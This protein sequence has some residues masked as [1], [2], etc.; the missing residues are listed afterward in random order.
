MLRVTQKFKDRAWARMRAWPPGFPAHGPGLFSIS[1]HCGVREPRDEQSW[2]QPCHLRGP[3]AKRTKDSPAMS[4]N[5][6]STM[7]LPAVKPCCC[8]S[9]AETRPLCG[10][11]PPG[12]QP[13]PVPWE[14]SRQVCQGSRTVQ[15]EETEIPSLAEERKL[16]TKCFFL[17]AG[18][19]QPPWNFLMGVGV[20]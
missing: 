13:L 20:G 16:K 4:G 17:K 6:R 15:S 9:E 5:S 3:Q 7:V 8:Y 12:L 19:K 14:D 2:T 18:R 11:P 10:G 1:P